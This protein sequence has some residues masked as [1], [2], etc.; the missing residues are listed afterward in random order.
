MADDDIGEFGTW[1]YVV[2]SLMLG[3]SVMI[4]VYHAWIGGKKQTNKDFL[5]AGGNMHPIP[6]ATS[7]VATFI[8]AI[9][10]LGTPAEMYTYGAMYWLFAF[11]FVLTGL[12]VV[13]FTMPFFFRLTSCTSANE[14]SQLTVNGKI[15]NFITSWRLLDSLNLLLNI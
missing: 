4:G 12:F 8:S 9:T 7:L 2:F 15:L 11:S 14:V 13:R 1:D 10:V 5:L 6:V 3:I